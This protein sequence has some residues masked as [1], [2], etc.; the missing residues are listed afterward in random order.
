[1]SP[2]MIVR[3]K[4]RWKLA[5]PSSHHASPPVVWTE[6]PIDAVSYARA[7]FAK[8]TPR[9]ITIKPMESVS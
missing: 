4:P 6:Q 2:S 8:S 7:I 5:F 3:S 9:G 1:M